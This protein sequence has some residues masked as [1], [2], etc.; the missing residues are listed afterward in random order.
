LI[1]SVGFFAFSA[2]FVFTLIVR[3]SIP[4]LKAETRSAHYLG[5]ST[6]LTASGGFSLGIVLKNFRWHSVLVKSI[7]LQI[8]SILI[9]SVVLPISVRATDKKRF[10]ILMFLFYLGVDTT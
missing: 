1:P 7:A 2:F 10:A 9:I 4:F 5:I 3:V 6:L 8:V